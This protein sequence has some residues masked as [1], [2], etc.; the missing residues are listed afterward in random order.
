MLD[1]LNKTNRYRTV[2]AEF[3]GL[4][5]SASS[6]FPRAYYQRIAERYQ[7]LAEGKSD[8]RH[9]ETAPSQSAAAC[10]FPNAMEPK[11]ADVNDRGFVRIMR[12]VARRVGLQPSLRTS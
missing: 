6:D 10:A 11:L 9:D 1:P 2:A 8:L 4:A 12:K 7:S 5:K 3:A